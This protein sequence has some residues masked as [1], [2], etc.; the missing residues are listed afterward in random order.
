M[1]SLFNAFDFDDN[2]TL[3]QEEVSRLI[4]QLYPHAGRQ[5]HARALK[6]VQSYFGGD[7]VLRVSSFMAAVRI[8]DVSLRGPTDSQAGA[9]ADAASG[10]DEKKQSV[11]KLRLPRFSEQSMRRMHLARE[12]Y[13][14]P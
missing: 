10:S 6:V 7:G 12:C 14:W 5:A 3:D 2:G 8:V 13:R 4:E 11:R 1:T 9:T